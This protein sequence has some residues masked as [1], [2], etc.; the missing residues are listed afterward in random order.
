MQSLATILVQEHSPLEILISDNWSKDGTREHCL[1]LAVKD[2]RVRYLRPPGPLGVFAHHNYV[3]RQASGPFVCFFHDDDLYR[4]TIVS[5]YIAFLEEHPTAG[6][7]CSDWDRIDEAGSLI[8]RHTHAVPRL[9]SGMQYVERT[10]PRARSAL[11]LSGAMFRREALGDY[12]FDEA[13]PLGFTDW[14]AWF[15]IAERYDIGHIRET[16][17][18]YRSHRRALSDKPAGVIAADYDRAV[19]AYCDEYLARHPGEAARVARWRAAIRRLRFWTVFYDV[20]TRL[21]SRPAGPSGDSALDELQAGASGP[22]ERTSTTMLRV[23]ARTGW[24]LPFA[25]LARYAGAGRTL[26]GLR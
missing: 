14:V 7:V 9:S 11:V 21:A 4:P 6:A 5:R 19:N 1:E 18:S 17:W 23:L 8:G 16:L 24:R 26:L 25:L 22:L 12:P 2:P 15:R 20:T 13:G 10:L 3:L